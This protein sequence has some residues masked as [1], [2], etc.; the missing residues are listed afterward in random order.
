MQLAPQTVQELQNAAAFGFDA[1]SLTSFPLS[2]RTATAIPVDVR[3]DILKIASHLRC[4]LGEKVIRINAYLSLKVK[5]HASADLVHSLFQ[6][7]SAPR[8]L[9]CPPQPNGDCATLGL[10]LLKRGALS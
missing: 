5:C 10:D 4:L 2:F 1:V 6:F 9:L 3:P 8:L 7:S